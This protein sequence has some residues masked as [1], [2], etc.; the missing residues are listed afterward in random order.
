MR[1]LPLLQTDRLTGRGHAC[2]TQA[3]DLAGGAKFG[4]TP[5]FI[6]CV[7]SLIAMVLQYTTIK[8]RAPATR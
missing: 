1:A 7:S 4:Y 6:I 3:T 8:V 2:R 5:L